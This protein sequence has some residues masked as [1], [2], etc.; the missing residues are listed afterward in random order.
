M[1][2]S[3]QQSSVHVACA[4]AGCGMTPK[5]CACQSSNAG[6]EVLL[7]SVV[8]AFISASPEESAKSLS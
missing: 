2:I 4:L 1:S 5:R 7:T 3:S 8:T 6:V